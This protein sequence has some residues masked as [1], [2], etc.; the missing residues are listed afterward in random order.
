[1]ASLVTESQTS[2]GAIEAVHTISMFPHHRPDGWD[3]CFAV[4]A[5]SHT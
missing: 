1:M 3:V 4:L 2:P 5:L